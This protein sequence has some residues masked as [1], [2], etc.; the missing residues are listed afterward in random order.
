M[1][2]RYEK[3]DFMPHSPDGVLQF[4]FEEADDDLTQRYN[5][6]PTSTF[7][8]EPTLFGSLDTGFP[9]SE[10]AL[11][12][13]FLDHNPVDIGDMADTLISAYDGMNSDSKSMK[14]LKRKRNTTS[15]KMQKTKVRNTMGNDMD[16]AAPWIRSFEKALTDVGNASSAYD[17]YGSMEQ[18]RFAPVPAPQPVAEP[19]TSAKV[20]PKKKPAKKSRS[21]K[22]SSQYRGVSRCSKDGRWQARIRIG[23]TVKYL[24]RFK[25]EIE[26]ARCY[27]VAACEYH[28][29][30]AVPNF[31]KETVAKASAKSK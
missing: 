5:A 28:G 30:R 3:K 7:E 9:D 26:A 8:F 27:D 6:Q 16:L 25:T 13:D 20:A 4:P 18:I 29:H 17:P 19:V 22:Q 14:S 12:A 15:G 10:A 2:S 11:F 1:M 24:G 21:K 23:S 31:P